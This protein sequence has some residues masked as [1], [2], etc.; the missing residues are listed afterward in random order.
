M[1]DED[2]DAELLARERGEEGSA[3]PGPELARYEQ[4]KALLADLPAVPEDAPESDWSERV[5][6][7]IDEEAAVRRSPKQART[8][9]QR[10]WWPVAAAAIA[11]AAIVAIIAIVPSRRAALGEDTLTV[12]A[13]RSSIPRLTQEVSVGD[14]LV[15]RGTS[16]V[17]AELRVYDDSGAEI[18]R[19][20]EPGPGCMVERERERLR[21]RLAVP[22]RMPGQLRPVLFS[23]S[24]AGSSRGLDGDVA[25]AVRRN[26]KVT[27]HQ[28]I[29]VR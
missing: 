6:A 2:V 21:L 19:C 5:L 15:V 10:R 12:E 23:A 20:S 16:N 29:L 14:T 11:S 17:G 4:L 25:E 1:R 28:P 26:L 22:L 13:E 8:R 18:A 3:V 27:T 24:L 9:T 7:T